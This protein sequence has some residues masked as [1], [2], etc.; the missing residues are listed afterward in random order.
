MKIL[1]F[2]LFL[3]L[4][5]CKKKNA[6]FVVKGIITDETFNKGL[7]GAEISI[8]KI[9]TGSTFET[10]ISTTTVAS[11]GSYSFSFDRDKSEKYTIKFTKENYFPIEKSISFS[12]LSTDNDNLRN[13]STT[14]KSW[15]KLHFKNIDPNDSDELRYIKQDGK[16]GC[17]EC[18]GT[19]YQ[20]LK[21]AADTSI[22]CI[23]DGN[24]TYSYLYAVLNSTNQAIKSV[25]TVPFDTTEI[26]LEY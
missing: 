12:S 16:F 4:I 15:V 19:T 24:T 23:N 17:V 1:Y 22:Y 21:G 11:D 13:Y 3:S 10:L 5:S 18:C 9:L 26:Y 20:Y 14:A 2:L 7:S 6:S 25:V 8:Y